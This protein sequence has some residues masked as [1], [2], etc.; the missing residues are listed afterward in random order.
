MSGTVSYFLGKQEGGFSLRG[1]VS[2]RTY[3]MCSPWCVSHDQET[4]CKWFATIGSVFSFILPHACLAPLADIWIRPQ[5][6]LGQGRDTVH[7]WARLCHCCPSPA[8]W[9]GLASVFPWSDFTEMS[10]DSR[11]H[12]I[13]CRKRFSRHSDTTFQERSFSV[14]GFSY[15]PKS[16]K[17]KSI[18]RKPN[19]DVLWLPVGDGYVASCWYICWLVA[20]ECLCFLH[21]WKSQLNSLLL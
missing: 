11:S 1:Q 10:L 18:R 2:G 21:L 20:F 12:R 8:V 13:S 3:L 19:T 17:N 5:G 4:H 14:I 7:A 9:V 15:L 16:N 6:W